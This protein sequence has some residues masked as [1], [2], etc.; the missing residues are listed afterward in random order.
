MHDQDTASTTPGGDSTSIADGI[1]TTGHPT[2]RQS[3]GPGRTCYILLVEDDQSLAS[4]EASTLIAQGFTVVSVESGERAITALSQMRPDLVV[5]DL[6]LTGSVTGW[7]VLRTIRAQST[8]APIP[9]LLTTS[10]IATVRTYIQVYG[11][12]KLTLDHLP[13]PYSI[14]TFLKRVRRMLV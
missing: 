4:L 8:T 3:A 2:P 6:E 1:H 5:L 14:P 12:S 10:S 13:K 9:V 11:E 7:D